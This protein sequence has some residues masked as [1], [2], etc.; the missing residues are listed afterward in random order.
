[1]S[2]ESPHGKKAIC[3]SCG[4][5]GRADYSHPADGPEFDDWIGQAHGREVCHVCYKDEPSDG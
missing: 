4:A 2:D 3:A 1:M 5:E